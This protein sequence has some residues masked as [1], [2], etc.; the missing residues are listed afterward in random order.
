MTNYKDYIGKT[1]KGFEFESTQYSGLGYSILMNKFIGKDLKIKEYR[2]NTNS[3]LTDADYFYPADLVIAQLEKQE[4]FKPKRGNKV[5]VWDHEEENAN[6]CIFLTQIEGSKYPYVC[7]SLAHEEAFINGS[8]FSFD[9]WKNIKPLP[10]KVIP[11]DTLVWVKNDKSWWFQMYYS[12]FSNG[13][14]YCFLDQKKSNETKETA[15]WN[16]VTTENPFQ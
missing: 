11:K 7:V 8:L 2:E 5:L 14:H 13:E 6:E 9:G 12:H 3:F 10:E 1:F 4:T 15:G 16:I